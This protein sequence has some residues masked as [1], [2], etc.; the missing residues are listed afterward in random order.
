MSASA[1]PTSSSGGP[2]GP[3]AKKRKE[4]PTSASG[5]SKPPGG[6]L[7]AVTFE[8]EACA[9]GGS[10]S[11]EKEMVGLFSAPENAIGTARSVLFDKFPELF[12]EWR[13]GGGE[14]EEEED[15][16]TS[17]KKGKAAEK[18]YFRGDVEVQNQFNE[19]YFEETWAAGGTGQITGEPGCSCGGATC[20][21]SVT[22]AKINE[23][24]VIF[25]KKFPSS[26]KGAGAE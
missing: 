26:A 8:L 2:G 1:P 17:K 5:S 12:Q 16:A 13:Y 23:T 4:A 14:E 25:P 6:S 22:K 10:D 18:L 7:F 19:G 3:G 24:Q 15:D 21:V 9:C 20:K 11:G